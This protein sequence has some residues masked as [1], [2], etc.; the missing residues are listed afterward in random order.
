MR[1]TMMLANLPANLPAYTFPRE[2]VTKVVTT[3]SL[4]GHSLVC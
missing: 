2:V 1:A 4:A 3:R